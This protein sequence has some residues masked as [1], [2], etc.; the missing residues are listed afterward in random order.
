MEAPDI[1]IR[2]AVE[3]L[4]PASPYAPQR[5][6][7]GE[8]HY[9]GR[10]Y[11]WDRFASVD[12]ALDLIERV[13]VRIADGRYEQWTTPIQPADYRIVETVSISRVVS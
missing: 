3:F 10:W 12:G 5:W 9:F 2:Y 8:D 6:Q 1:E 4:I 7:S 11:R 13:N